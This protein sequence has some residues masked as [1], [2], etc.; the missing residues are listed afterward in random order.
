MR[1]DLRRAGHFQKNREHFQ[2][3]VAHRSTVVKPQLGIQVAIL[4]KTTK[5]VLLKM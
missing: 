4:P 1:S 2:F 5:Y 3:Q